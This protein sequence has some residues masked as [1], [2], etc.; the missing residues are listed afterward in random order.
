MPVLYA[1][2]DDC[3]FVLYIQWAGHQQELLLWNDRFGRQ[4]LAES[5]IYL[6]AAVR[7][8]KSLRPLFGLEL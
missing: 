4:V 2:H 7:Q 8:P 1:K 3:Q 5:T 6:M